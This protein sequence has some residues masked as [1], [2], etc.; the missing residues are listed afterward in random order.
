MAVFTCI[1]FFGMCANPVSGADTGLDCDRDG[2]SDSVEDY[3]MKKYAPVVYLHPDDEF[4]PG[5]VDWYLGR[6]ELEY[7]GATILEL[8]TVSVSNLISQEK[9]GEYSG[10][11]TE[12]TKFRLVHADDGERDLLITFKDW[13]KTGY[14]AY[15][16]GA[17]IGSPCY[18]HVSPV[19]GYPEFVYIQYWFFYPYNGDLTITSPDLGI[20]AGHHEGD[21]EHITV[22]VKLRDSGETVEEVY[23]SAHKNEGKWLVPSLHELWFIDETHPVVYSALHSHASYPYPEVIHRTWAD[24][25]TSDNGPVWDTRGKCKNMGELDAPYPGMDWIRFTGR[26]GHNGLGFCAPETPTMRESW[27]WEGGGFPAPR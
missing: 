19:Q 25:R 2:L 3:L 22:L 14:S 18:V 9:N 11:G 5:G 24:D 7:D 20:G 17:R 8:G 10:K 4:Q 16:K 15:G 6:V 27:S 1:L 23:Y 13:T 21:W 26:W 12:V